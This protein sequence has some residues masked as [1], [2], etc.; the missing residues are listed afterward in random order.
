METSHAT[1]SPMAD[2]DRGAQ[3]R[4]KHSYLEPIHN[5]DRDVVGHKC[6]ECGKVLPLQA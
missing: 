2:T 1:K 4:C 3:D 5:R 6:R